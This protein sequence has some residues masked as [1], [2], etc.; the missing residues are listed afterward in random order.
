MC[1]IIEVRIYGEYKG[2]AWDVDELAEILSC[3]VGE[4]FDEDGQP[5]D[6]G[7]CLCNFDI[8][9]AAYDFGYSINWNPEFGQVGLFKDKS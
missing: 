5:Y 6:E 3:K 7:S 4:L 1:Q 8:A 9:R 2:S